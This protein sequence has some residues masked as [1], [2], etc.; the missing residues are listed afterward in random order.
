MTVA[1]YTRE[2]Y[3]LTNCGQKI[4]DEVRGPLFACASLLS[5]DVTQHA[6]IAGYDWLG[7]CM[8]GITV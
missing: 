8:C 6:H 5:C 2:C 7:F 1:Y 3:T 4:L